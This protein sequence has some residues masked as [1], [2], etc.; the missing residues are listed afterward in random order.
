MSFLGL[1]KVGAFYLSY[2]K[3]GFPVTPAA[4]ISNAIAAVFQFLAT[5]AG[6]TLCADF[7]AIDVAFAGKLKDLFDKIHDQAHDEVPAPKP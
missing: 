5:P 3:E 1:H 6:Q 2:P 4:A 7:R